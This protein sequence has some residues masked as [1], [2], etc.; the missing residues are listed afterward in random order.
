M[1]KS[2]YRF[3]LTRTINTDPLQVMFI[4]VNP[5]TATH[6]EDDQTTTKLI[7]FAK[8]WGYGR[9]VL[10]NVY[11]YRAA[12]IQDLA[13]YQNEQ[14][15]RNRALIAK[16][17]NRSML[18]VPMWGRLSKIPGHLTHEIPRIE[19]LISSSG[20]E[21]RCFGTNKDGTPKHPLMLPYNT[22]MEDYP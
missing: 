13:I 16:S 3:N 11:P 18:V 14:A 1:S 22:Q 17:L 20:I 19:N 8:R 12:H 21:C 6:T 4:G 7:E 15:S 9:Y 5:S 2:K 10:F